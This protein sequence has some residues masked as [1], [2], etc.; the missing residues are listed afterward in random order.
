MRTDFFSLKEMFQ[1]S[2]ATLEKV[3][4]LSFSIFMSGVFSRL[5]RDPTGEGY[6]ALIQYLDS[7]LL[8]IIIVVLGIV[9]LV[10]S[11]YSEHIPSWIS[12]PHR[13]YLVMGLLLVFSYLSGYLMVDSTSVAASMVVAANVLLVAMAVNKERMGVRAPW[14]VSRLIDRE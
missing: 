11:Y 12:H 7:S 13:F 2:R 5:I 1:E 8:A 14:L 4:G 6:H 9:A 10:V 3:L